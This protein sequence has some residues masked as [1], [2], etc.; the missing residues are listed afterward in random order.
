[1]QNMIEKMKEMSA[2]DLRY[3]DRNRLDV[4]LKKVKEAKYIEN[5]H[6][7]QFHDK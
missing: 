5:M 3:F 2:R 1:V 6:N 4:F 7:E